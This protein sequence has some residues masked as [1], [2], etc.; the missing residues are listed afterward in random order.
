MAI[1]AQPPSYLSLADFRA[2]ASG[3]V[4]GL[5]ASLSDP[6]V[7]AILNAASGVADAIMRRSLLAQEVTVYRRGDGSATLELNRSPLIY[8]RQIAFAQ[9][10][11]G[12]YVIPTQNILIDYQSGGLVTFTPLLLQGIGYVARFPRDI[13]MAVRF[14][15]GY[16][17]TLPEPA[18]SSNDTTVYG[19]ASLAP[20]AYNIAVTAKSNW[21]E[22][23]AEVR[24][25]LVE[26]GAVKI[27]VTPSLG[28]E[29]YRVFMAP[30]GQEPM[31]VAE[32]PS[33]SFAD[34]ALST[35]V[36]S[37]VS[38][39]G[40]FPETL[41]TADTSAHV[42]P[43][44]IVEATR[45]LALSSIAEDANPASLGVVQD[46][47]LRFTQTNATPAKMSAAYQRA[48]MM[49]EPYQYSAVL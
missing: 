48:A 30:T 39:N 35:I 20:G 25:V 31:L 28:A 44:A 49:L 5:V 22:T 40:E 13:E 45:I 38:P 24:M 29:R 41:P 2:G 46:N 7:Q 9:P 47:T 10:G 21:G 42:A 34:A 37:L 23:N 36:T 12:G 16:G 4:A 17:Y 19:A 18:W 3:V 11:L 33:T 32:I 8:V 43:P 1:L 26:S 15:Y 14:A 27:T 6:Q